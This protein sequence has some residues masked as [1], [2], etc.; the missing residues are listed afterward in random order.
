MVMTEQE[1]HGLIG[2]VDEYDMYH[3]RD[4]ADIVSINDPNYIHVKGHK[5]GFDFEPDVIFDLGAN[6]GVFTRYAG[7]LFP[8]A[9]IVAVEPD[10]DNA[11]V[12]L[13]Y[14]NDD[15]IKFIKGAIGTGM[16]VFRLHGAANGSGECYVSE[17]LG[18][19]DAKKINGEK[20]PDIKNY[21]LSDVVKD[22]VHDGNKYI[23]KMDIEGA[24]NFV[25]Q[26]EPSIRALLNA[27][28]FT[29]E[30]HWFANDAEQLGEVTERT[31]E[32]LKRFEKTHTCEANHIYFYATKKP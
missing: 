20:R 25:F 15:R 12:F 9:R 1:L 10:D 14:S 7:K 24:E 23:I 2:E 17:G 27:D 19:N 26:H 8:N 13:S 32:I 4:V 31:K 16:D 18:Y 11:N 6:I 29:M 22:H 3:M 5:R 21:F 30:L 28:Y